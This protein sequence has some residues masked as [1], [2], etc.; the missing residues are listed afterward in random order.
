MAIICVEHQERAEG[1]THPKKKRCNQEHRPKE[2]RA[3]K[4]AVDREA[5]FESAPYL[6]G[7]G[8][9]KRPI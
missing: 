1:F 9:L 3:G 8:H 5:E 4:N 2:I 7:C 6:N